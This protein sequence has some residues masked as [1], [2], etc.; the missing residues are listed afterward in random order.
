MKK[1]IAVTAGL[2][3]LPLPRFIDLLLVLLWM[4][5]EELGE[6]TIGAYED[7]HVMKTAKALRESL[8][9]DVDA[10]YL[11]LLTM[12]STAERERRRRASLARARIHRPPQPVIARASAWVRRLAERG[13]SE[14]MRPATG[15]E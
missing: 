6:L 2:M 15:E 7:Y 9:A 13:E 4:F 10:H 8:D 11:L 5:R 3:L 1:A 14:S 12:R